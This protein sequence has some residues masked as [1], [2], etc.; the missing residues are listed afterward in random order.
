MTHFRI[1]IQSASL[2]AACVTRLIFAHATRSTFTAVAWATWAAACN[3]NKKNP[4]LWT[5][6]EKHLQ[7]V[8]PL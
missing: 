3:K 7:K 2:T 5:T 1:L 8:P 6:K 4:L